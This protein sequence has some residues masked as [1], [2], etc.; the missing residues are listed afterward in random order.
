M[1]NID[2]PA[3]VGAPPLDTSPWREFL[4]DS[5]AR[6]RDSVHRHYRSQNVKTVPHLKNFHFREWSKIREITDPRKFSTIRYI[7]ITLL[8]NKVLWSL[9]DNWMWEHQKESPLHFG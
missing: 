6:S 7:V 5:A 3:G 1:L 8:L 9:F 2:V 4:T